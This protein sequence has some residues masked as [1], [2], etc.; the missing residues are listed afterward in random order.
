[1]CLPGNP[2]CSLQGRG[3]PRPDMQKVVLLG[4][5]LYMKFPDFDYFRQ[6]AA[7]VQAEI[8]S[9]EGMSDQDILEEVKNA[10]ALVVI[11]YPVTREMIGAAKQCKLIMTLSVGYDVVD[12]EAAT[13]RGIVVSN[14]PLYCSEEVAEHAVT[15]LLGVS[16]K[17]HELI[18]HV[19]EGGWDYKQARPIH[20]FRTR[21]FG[22]IGLGRIGR[23]AARKAQGLGM[24]V[25]AYDP[26]VDD[27]IFELLGVERYYDLYPMLE[28]TDSISIHA[29]LTDETYHL[30][31]AEALAKM[32]SH[33]VLVN[34]ARGSIVDQNALEDA[35]EAG[36]IGGAGIDVLETEPPTGRERLLN[37]PN[38]I[39]TPHIAWYSE[40]SHRQ[41]Q[42]DG[43]DELV[44]VLQG[45]RPRYIVNPQ[46][47]SRR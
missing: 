2:L 43:M 36:N 8:A 29:P 27:D 45:R 5:R 26:Y 14:C 31:D 22:I 12:L 4:N 10:A 42:I 44:R 35:L 25:V 20:S 3:Y 46:I 32:Q 23:H 19:R 34:T 24:R 6:R 15:L 17:L 28:A 7:E 33:A 47:F 13:E 39:V 41:N 30:I 16:R 38:A 1:M 18:P 40:E 11:G 9:T 37:L 21:R